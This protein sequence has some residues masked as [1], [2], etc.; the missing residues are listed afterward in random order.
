MM[1]GIT[2]SFGFPYASQ[3]FKSQYTLFLYFKFQA[4]MLCVGPVCAQFWVN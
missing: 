4:D 2:A 1:A 3:V